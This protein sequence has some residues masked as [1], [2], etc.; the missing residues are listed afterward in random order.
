MLALIPLHTVAFVGLVLFIAGFIIYRAINR[1]PKTNEIMD[2]SEQFPY[3]E[4]ADD[5]IGD[6]DERERA[7]DGRRRELKNVV[8]TSER[9]IRKIEKRK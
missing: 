6:I 1:S 2:M 7:L 8:K 5:I 3:P 9:E 4:T